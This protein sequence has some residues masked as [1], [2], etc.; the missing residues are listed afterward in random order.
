[1]NGFNC[2]TVNKRTLIVTLFIG[3]LCGYTCGYIF[4]NN[5]YIHQTQI[6]E[7]LIDR[8]NEEE[9]IREFSKVQPEG[10]SF[11]NSAQKQTFETQNR[12][13]LLCW[14]MT[15]PVNHK[16]K[17]VHVKAT[18]GRRCDILLFM[19]SK[20]D[21]NLPAVALSVNEGRNNLWAKT[22]K[23][24]AHIYD[25]YFDQADWF[26]KAD[27]DTY[28]IVENL[29]YLLANH[30][31]TEAL[32]FGWRF[33]HYV[34]QGFMSGGAGYV[35]SKCALRKFILEGIPNSTICRPENDG[36]EDTE[37]GKCMENLGI[38][39]MDTRDSLE[40]DRFFP[41]VPI[42]KLISGQTPHDFWYFLYSY[43]PQKE[44]IECCSNSAISFHYVS[45]EMMY[46]IENLIYNINPYGIDRKMNKSVAVKYGSFYSNNN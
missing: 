14:V 11:N 24:F 25:N 5:F 41:L 1:M 21:V 2:K 30:N 7:I 28:M 18:W 8:F 27:D 13:R 16:T 34:K 22:K 17:A 10:K 4:L 12:V 38:P 43:Y 6:K 31:T 37:M 46:V 42:T 33:K 40:R 19:S 45:P 35:L 26:Y 3:V 32:Y 20:G 29:K 15:S 44:G 36:N 9:T 39:A 23:A